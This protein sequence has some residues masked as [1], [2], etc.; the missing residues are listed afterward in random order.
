MVGP[1]M[2]DEASLPLEAPE[3][4]I[5]PHRRARIVVT[6]QSLGAIPPSCDRV[7]GVQ[8]A[9]DAGHAKERIAQQAARARGECGI[10]VART[11]T[12]KWRA[13]IEGRHGQETPRSDEILQ[14][15][16]EAFWTF[17]EK[18]DGAER[19][20][21]EESLAPRDSESTEIAT[22]FVG[23]H[24]TLTAPMFVATRL[25]RSSIANPTKITWSISFNHRDSADPLPVGVDPRANFGTKSE[26]STARSERCSLPR[27]P[28]IRWK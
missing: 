27:R 26:S 16:D 10:V 13:M 4:R 9:H 21:H 23:S 2:Q 15:A 28:E 3:G 14:H 6:D 20:V 25:H 22:Q 24:L 11:G 17:G 1:E 18:A 12:G 5:W 7:R 19:S 8:G